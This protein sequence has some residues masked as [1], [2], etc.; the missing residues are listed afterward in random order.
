MR[1]TYTGSNFTPNFNDINA[2]ENFTFTA[3]AGTVSQS[4]VQASPSTFLLEVVNNT[5]TETT[6]SPTEPEAP[7]PLAE[8][9]S[10]LL[11]VYV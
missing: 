2:G 7:W 5:T 6:V 9:A 3:L 4:G 1:V 11:P 10:K 8:A